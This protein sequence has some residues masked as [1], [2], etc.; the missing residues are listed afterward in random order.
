MEGEATAGR[1]EWQAAA[2]AVTHTLLAA[3]A[4]AG[5]PN[6]GGL[7]AL[8]SNLGPRAWS[9]RRRCAAGRRGRARRAVQPFPVAGTA[10]VRCD[11]AGVRRGC[12]T[13]FAAAGALEHRAPACALRGGLVSECVL[14]AEKHVSGRV[15]RPQL[16]KWVQIRGRLEGRAQAWARDVHVRRWREVRGRVRGR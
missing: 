2:C 14:V 15:S 1:T 13:F 9:A 6:R 7:P 11:G 4:S 8:N 3:A 16:P 10:G 12:K 5:A